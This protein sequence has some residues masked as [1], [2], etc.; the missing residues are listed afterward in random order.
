MADVINRA[1]GNLALRGSGYIPKTSAGRIMADTS[2]GVDAKFGKPFLFQLFVMKLLREQG[3]T[4]RRNRRATEAEQSQGYVDKATG[5]W[6]A[7]RKY[8]S[9]KKQIKGI[10]GREISPSKY[11]S[12]VKKIVKRRINTI[13]GLRATLGYVALQFGA[14]A[15]RFARKT[16]VRSARIVKAVPN[17][18]LAAFGYNFEDKKTPLMGSRKVAGQ[19]AVDWRAR[20]TGQALNRAVQFVALD[21]KSDAK[22]KLT[23]QAA[24]ISARKA[25]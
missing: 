7:R 11:W 20:V 8:V 17:N 12:I 3:F 14:R 25:A 5:K 4:V 21:M 13:G 9:V 6:V 1:A 10:V 15:D 24:R 19:K 23:E 22:K 2:G 18:W 16:T